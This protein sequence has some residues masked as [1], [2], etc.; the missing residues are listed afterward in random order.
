MAAG[1]LAVL[2]TCMASA[3]ESL[4]FMTMPSTATTAEGT[5]AALH[6]LTAGFDAYK[7]AL[8]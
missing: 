2:M 7:I 4:S 6:Q 5:Q 3:A 8:P 1:P